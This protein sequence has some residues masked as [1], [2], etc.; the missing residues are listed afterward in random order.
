MKKEQY[1]VHDTD[2]SNRKAFYEY[3]KNKYNLK[4]RMTK[5]RMVQNKFPFV[6]DFIDNSFWV[7]ESITCCAC[8]AQNKKIITI[9]KFKEKENNYDRK[10]KSISSR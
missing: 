3:I 4:I 8:A 7:C 1:M 9:E 5:K 10:S 6:I 2:I